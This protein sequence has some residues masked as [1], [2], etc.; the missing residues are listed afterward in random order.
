MVCAEAFQGL[1]FVED[2]ASSVPCAVMSAQFASLLG[3]CRPMLHSV[4]TEPFSWP[5]HVVSVP[6]CFFSGLVLS[7]HSALCLNTALSL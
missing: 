2:S 3:H 5:V 1:L 4:L 6:A 7:A